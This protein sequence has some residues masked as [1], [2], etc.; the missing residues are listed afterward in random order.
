MIGAVRRLGGTR[1]GVGALVRK[2]SLVAVQRPEFSLGVIQKVGQR[3]A[4]ILVAG[5]VAST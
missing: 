3:G 2:K 4:I 1:S 5:V